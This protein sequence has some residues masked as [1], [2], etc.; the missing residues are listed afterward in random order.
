MQNAV[1]ARERGMEAA[2]HGILRL[3]GE[4][5]TLKN[6]LAQ[7]D[8]YLAALERDSAKALKEEQGATEDLEWLGVAKTELST[9]LAARQM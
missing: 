1:A 4:G 3:L 8:T 6:Q 9:K 2:R 5:A 7:A